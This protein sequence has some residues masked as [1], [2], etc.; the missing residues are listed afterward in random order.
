MSAYKGYDKG[1]FGSKCGVRHYDSESGRF[2]SPDPFKGYMG[3][4]QSQHP[5]MYCRG[6]PIK[7]SDPTGT[8]Y[9]TTNLEKNYDDF[10]KVVRI[11]SDAIDKVLSNK[12]QYSPELVKICKYIKTKS[13][14]SGYKGKYDSP[15]YPVHRGEVVIGWG[16]EYSEAAWGF[17]KKGYNKVFLDSNLLH[18]KEADYGI[19]IQISSGTLLHELMHQ[20]RNGLGVE[21]LGKEAEESKVRKDVETV[22]PNSQ[23]GFSPPGSDGKI[24]F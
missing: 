15:P 10:R 6:N 19:Y 20:A 13:L 22:L 3:D 8:Y 14:G 23:P 2:I 17:Y 4:P 1:P 16:K 9:T 24:R 21:T 12:K 11:V 7:Y 5:Y 18:F